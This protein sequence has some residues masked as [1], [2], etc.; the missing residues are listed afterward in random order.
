MTVKFTNCKYKVGGGERPG[1]VPERLRH[2]QNTHLYVSHKF[3]DTR[4]DRELKQYLEWA[5]GYTI[6]TSK[7]TKVTRD[8]NRQ[9]FTARLRGKRKAKQKH[10]EL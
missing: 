9:A 5:S 8:F 2:N 10:H 6:L 7:S 3:A 4:T 1:A